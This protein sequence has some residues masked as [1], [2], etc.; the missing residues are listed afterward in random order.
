MTAAEIAAKT[1][2]SVGT[3]ST[4]L[5]RMAKAGELVKAPRGYALPS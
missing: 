1:E 5:S 2:I 3:V 4:T